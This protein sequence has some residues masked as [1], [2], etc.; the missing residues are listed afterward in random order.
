MK[1]VENPVQIHGNPSEIHEISENL[2]EV[3]LSHFGRSQNSI[4]KKKAQREVFPGG[5]R[6]DKEDKGDKGDKG[7]R[8]IRVIRD[9]GG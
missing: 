6:G 3:Y 4:R 5:I 2:C 1:S 9:K 7:I 8:V